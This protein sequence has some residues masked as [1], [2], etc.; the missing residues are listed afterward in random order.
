MQSKYERWWL[1]KYCRLRFSMGPFRKVIKIKLFGPPSF[2]YGTVELTFE[3]GEIVNVC[4]VH[5][6]RP[7]K[8]DV[9]VKDD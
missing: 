9:E 1:G 7:R 2:V 6:F 8:Y 3:D 4:T 5:S